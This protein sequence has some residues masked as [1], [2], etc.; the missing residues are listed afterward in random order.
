MDRQHVEL[1]M[2]AISTLRYSTLMETASK[3]CSAA[4]QIMEMM[5]P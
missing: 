3:L 5:E 4:G 1:A 2:T